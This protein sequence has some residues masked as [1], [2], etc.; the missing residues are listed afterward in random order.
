[1]VMAVG[2]GFGPRSGVPDRQTRV[3]GLWDGR[4]FS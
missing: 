2:F 3:V 4:V 1:M